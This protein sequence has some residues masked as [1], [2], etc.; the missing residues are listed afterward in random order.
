VV[1]IG[2]LVPHNGIDVLIEAMRNIDAHLLIVGDGPRRNWLQ[3]QIDDNEL[4]DRVTLWGS[5]SH[6][7]LRA[8]LAATDVFAL[9]SLMPSETFGIVQLEAMACGLPIVNTA[10]P[11]SASWMA[12]DRRE[13]ITVIPDSAIALSNAIRVLLTDRRLAGRLGTAGRTRATR[14]FALSTFEDRVTQIYNQV[15]AA[16]KQSVGEACLPLSAMTE[17]ELQ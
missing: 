5:A 10:L 12:R 13:A 6:F 1:T 9:P 11:T 14:T 16:R 4:G 8:I 17:A 15:I 2:Q 3:A 7:E